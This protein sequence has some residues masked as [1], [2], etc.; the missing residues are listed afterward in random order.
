[1][2][3]KTKKATALV[4]LALAL[5][6]ALSASLQI[7]FVEDFSIGTV[8]ARG[9]EAYFFVGHSREG[10]HPSYLKYLG[11]VVAA[12]LNVPTPSDDQRGSGLVIHVTPSMVERFV[13]EDTDENATSVSFMTPFDDG[14]Y[15]LCA[16]DIFCKWTSKGFR[17]AT[18]EEERSHGGVGGLFRGTDI[19][20]ILNGWHEHRTTLLPGQHFKVEFGQGFELDVQNHATE[21]S[22]TSVSV[23]LLRPG[24]PPESLYNVSGIPRRVS[25]A[26]YERIFKKP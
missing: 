9:D 15:A 25:K 24:Q 6:L 16:A 19:D 20:L 22:Y 12:K 3:K 17:P 11:A 7:Y 14:F 5:V 10:F 13:F 8:F 23:D 1:M 4:F 26:E 2:N 21:M 18:K